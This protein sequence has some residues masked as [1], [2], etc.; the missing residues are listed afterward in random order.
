MEFLLAALA[1]A[2]IGALVMRQLSRR[3]AQPASSAG[4]VATQPQQE[5]P[6]PPSTDILRTLQMQ[7]EALRPVY[8]NS[9]HPQELESDPAFVAGTALLED[10][11]VPFERVLDYCIGANQQIAVMAAGALAR[12]DDGARAIEVLV[13]HLPFANVWTDF[14]MLRAI[15]RHAQQPIVGRVLSQAPG[16]WK[17][18]P[19]LPRMLDIFVESR[20]VKGETLDLA[21]ALTTQTPEALADIEAFLKKLN[22]PPAEMLRAQLEQWKR[23]RVDRR[24]LEAIGRIWGDDTHE[25]IIVAHAAHKST[26]QAV[27]D[28]IESGTCTSTILIGESGAGKS[29]AFRDIGQDLRRR[30]WTIFEASASDVLAGMAY[31]GELEGR[32]RQLLDNAE[33]RRRIVWY[34]PNF[35]ELFYAGRHKYSPVGLLDLLLPAIEARR[36]LIVGESEPGAFDRILQHRSRLRTAVKSVKI[37]PLAAPE[38]LVVAR[39]LAARQGE[40]QRTK[41]E[42]DLADEALELARHYLASHALP[43]SVLALLRHAFKRAAAQSDIELRRSHLFEC[44]TELTGLPRSVLDD[45]TGLDYA[46]LQQRFAARVMGQQEAIECLVD[47]IA[48]LKAG[49][50]D[51]KRPIGVFMFAGPTGTGKTEVARTLAELLFGGA[52]RMV[53]LDMSE[54][55]EPSSLARILGD[56][57]EGSEVDS[58]ALRIRKQPFSVVLLDEFEKAH[59]RVWDLFLQVFDEGRLTDSTGALADFRHAVI[60]LTSNIGATRHHSSALG[61]T[62]PNATFSHAQVVRAVSEAFR[63]ELINRLDRL[64]IFTPLARSLMREILRK[65]LRDVLQRPGLRSRDW[66]VEWEES[67]IEFLLDKGFTADMGARPLRRAIETYVLAPIAKSIVEHRHPEGDQF[68]FVRSDGTAIQVEFVDPDMPQ[69]SVAAAEAPAGSLSLPAILQS[70]AGDDAERQFLLD[71]VGLLI[72]RIE[73]KTW[74]E[75]KQEMLRTMNRREFWAAP[76]RHEILDRIERMD[77]IEAAA[78]TAR[79]FALRLEQRTRSHQAVSRQ[80]V[81]SLAEQ[82]HLV[83]GALTDFDENRSSDAYVRVEA[84]ATDPRDTAS[85]EW[86]AKLARM[87]QEWGRKRRMRC[88]VLADGADRL[89]MTVSGLG[90]YC[91]LAQEAGLHVFEVPDGRGGFD[92]HTARVRVAAQPSTPEPSAQIELQ[93]ALKQLDAGDVTTKIVRRYREQPSPLVR[94]TRTS[95]RTGRLAQ[96]LNGDFDLIG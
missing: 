83:N 1:G 46:Q 86:T 11:T 19:L 90:A 45:R 58:L 23:T 63:P 8:E 22:A 81:C 9:S 17:D 33:V 35:H 38:A 40:A 27:L 10:E 47:R 30:G 60:I 69:P 15:D 24:A 25:E 20:A 13:N 28:D 18:N 21:S 41:I 94:D 42:G 95:A 96:I 74:V 87:Y 68:L 56:T 72:T 66:A 49:L 51:P 84:V 26:V 53:R 80:V 44:M 32:V 79:S 82:L 3:P 64:V 77:R 37:E 67:A 48:M 12:R 89:V 16:W 92:R 78:A 52:Q 88:N 85:T 4:Q 14:F 5:P 75:K 61:F 76:D 39:E 43:G 34:V 54:L 2:I 50:I 62:T 91:I 57:A 70:P 59:P 65:E 55:Q 31:I 36:V 93:R 71:Q 7:A 29:V 73:E 6:T